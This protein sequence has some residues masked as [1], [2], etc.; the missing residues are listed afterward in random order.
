[1][2]VQQDFIHDFIRSKTHMDFHSS[3]AAQHLQQETSPDS[4]VLN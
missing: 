1:M 4:V 2:Y 3:G